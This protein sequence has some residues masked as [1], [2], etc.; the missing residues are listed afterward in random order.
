M[1]QYETIKT[2]LGISEAF[3]LPSRLMACLMDAD[4]RHALL[5]KISQ[6][7]PDLSTDTLSVDFQEAI[8]DRKDLKQDFTPDGI[9]RLV[10][11]LATNGQNSFGDICAGSGSLTIAMRNYNPD[12]EF[13]IEELSQAA[14][15]MLLLNLAIRNMSGI[16]LNG[17]SLT[18][19]FRAGYR[20][21]RGEQFSEIVPVNPE[22]RQVDQIIMNPPY[23]LGWDPVMDE[24]FSYGLAPKSKADYAFV[25]HGL[26]KLTE[27]GELLAIL[28]HGVLF[29]SA[30]ELAIRTELI[31][32]GLLDMVIGLP[33]KMF[34]GTDIPT[35]IIKLSKERKHRDVLF[36]DASK[37][38]RQVNRLNVMDPEH[39]E[40]ILSVANHRLVVDKF[41]ALVTPE[42]MA[43]NDYNL[44]IPRYVD[45]FE[46]EEP[47]DLVRVMTEY[48]EINQEIQKAERELFGMMKGLVS[49]DPVDQI[50]HDKA[51]EVFREVVEHR[52]GQMTLEDL[53]TTIGP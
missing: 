52:S 19:E 17:D 22:P 10:A 9:A 50:Q 44:N 25:L 20:L 4:D 23:S 35:V 53:W 48:L 2:H 36:I 42:E 12:A 39:I 37:E 49:R 11:G 45:T 16:V 1:T 13:Y 7:N 3:E 28:P 26:S 34:H 51:V 32:A 43:H 40:K 14:L 21:R 46:P 24:R 47:I 8:G 30:A 5:T 6:S 31:R 33:G 27:A 41:S 29:R 18:R 15:P 38:C